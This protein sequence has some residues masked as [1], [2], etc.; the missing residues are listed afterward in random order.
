MPRIAITPLQPSSNAQ[1]ERTKIVAWPGFVVE[2]TVRRPGYGF[3]YSGSRS[4]HYLA[5]HD[6]V[7]ADG[8]TR[9]TGL[10]VSRQT[11]LRGKLTFV[12]S[13]CEASGWSDGGTEA[14]RVTMIFLE[15][16]ALGAE[17][18][19]VFKSADLRPRLY[20]EDEAL[21]Y[22]L[23][24]LDRAVRRDDEVLDLYAESVAQFLAGRLLDLVGD[25]EPDIPAEAMAES[26][27]AEA[28]AFL[29]A[30]LGRKISID[31]VAIVAGLSR[32]HFIKAF[33]KAMGQSPYQFLLRLRLEEAKRLLTTTR[34]SVEEIALMVGFSSSAQFV[35]MFKAVVGTTP[36]AYRR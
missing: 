21:R 8:E 31:D 35:R 20:F 34:L 18:A 30:N 25:G 15:P 29:R 19:H 17:R 10:P 28:V 5:L 24:T 4:E 33:R 11:D 32:F 3:A 36:G 27:F 22:A 9:V 7:R 26:R 13:G 2:S 1:I 23:E 12:P 16:S 6:I 14:P